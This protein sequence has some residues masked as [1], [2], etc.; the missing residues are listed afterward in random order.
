[1]LTRAQAIREALKEVPDP[2]TAEAKR[3]LAIARAKLAQVGS[4]EEVDGDHISKARYYLRQQIG[5]KLTRQNIEA[6][7]RTMPYQF[8]PKTVKPN[9]AP[10]TAARVTA[11]PAPAPSASA[12]LDQIR[13]AKEFA[14]KLGG[15]SQAIAALEILKELQQ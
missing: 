1:M 8:R 10:V 7:E 14:S 4:R 3:L 9:G 13:L 15:V 12:T 2:E 11:V 6:Y 5:Q